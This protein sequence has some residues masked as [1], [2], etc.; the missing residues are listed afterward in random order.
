MKKMLGA[1]DGN[2]TRLHR[3]A[4]GPLRLADLDIPVGTAR[5]PSEEELRVILSMVPSACR[6]AQARREQVD[7]RRQSALSSSQ[8]RP[9]KQRS[10]RSAAAPAAQAADA[11]GKV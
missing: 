7:S 2:V 5:A 8:P 4:I 9:P 11:N 3:E 6:T 1:C 10:G